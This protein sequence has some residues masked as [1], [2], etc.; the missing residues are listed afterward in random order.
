LDRVSISNLI[1]LKTDYWI[2]QEKKKSQSLI[3]TVIKYIEKTNRL[4]EPQKEAIK[5]YLWLKFVG[6][7]QRLS[8][9]IR[10]GLLYDEELAKQYNNF[11]T[12][13][14]NYTT[15]FLNQFFQD[16][17][18][19]KLHEKLVNDPYGQK[20]NWDNVLNELLYN[21]EY[22]NYL[23]SLP[24]GAGKTFLMACFIYLDL[25]FASL[26]KKDKRFAHNFIVLAPTASKTAI[27]PSLR[28]IKDF[29][30]EWILPKTEA[31]R[32]KQTIQIEILDALSSHRKDKLQGENPN[33]EKVNRLL[34]IKDF[35]LVFITNAEKV[36][37]EKYDE[38]DMVFV[39]A[40]KKGRK[41]LLKELSEIKKSNRLR[42]RLSEIPFLSV[43]LDE[44]HHAYKNKDKEKKS[45][46]AINILN[47]NKNVVS[48]L[49]FSG[50]P[51]VNYSINIG[52]NQIRL[53]Q[54]QDI[55]YN[56]SL[57]EGIGKF[58][59][60]PIVKSD[61]VNE[62]SFIRN[63]LTDFFSNF[64]IAYSNGTKSKM[65]F[66]CPSVKA[67]NEKILPIVK[68]W[69]QKNRKGKENEI[70]RYYSK[71]SKENKLYELPK[72]NL[73]LFHNLD[74]PYSE[75]R[76]VLLVAV[77]TE[78]WDCKSLTAISLPRQQT[79]KNFVLQTTCRCLREVEN[80]KKEKALIYLSEDNYKTLDEELQEN[81]RLRI[82]DL[83][84]RKDEEIPVLVKK[85]KLGKLKYKQVKKKYRVMIKREINYKNKL[86][87]FD[88]DIFKSKYKFERRVMKGTIGKEGIIKEVNLNV[89]E[90]YK[91]EPLNYS[92]IDFVYDISNE[93][94]GRLSES[95]LLKNYGKELKN[96][97]DKI[98]KEIEWIKENPNLELKDVIHYVASLFTR[99]VDYK[100]ETFA[101][102][103]EIELLEW[104]I[105]KPK[106][107]LRTANGTLFK[108]MP[109]IKEQDARLY[110]AHP[111]DLE[112]EIKNIDPQNISFNYIPYRMDSTFEQNAL[113]DMLKMSEL[114][115]LEV[116]YNGFKDKKLNSFYIET[117]RGKYT[118]D[119]LIIKRKDNE[120][121][122]NK[123][124]K[125]EIE[126]ILIIE[127]K[128]KLY[129]DNEFR[130]KERFIE[131][132]F[133]KE[134]PKFRYKCF[135]DK[136]KTNDFS[137]FLSELKKEIKS[138]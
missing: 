28:T 102:D 134:N 52:S 77:G 34:Q 50:T 31:Q 98:E 78:G 3:G 44:V 51:Y 128:G 123:D 91:K 106:M 48:V 54:I 107:E 57:N 124:D 60:V 116:Y 130:V 30:P 38:K 23:F 13:G 133:I 26:Y 1:G 67:L 4:R 16:N 97:F 18:I 99:E 63:A 33:L 40:L 108:F 7:N 73:A 22:P 45:R 11:Y 94:F 6:K 127:T 15:Q 109:K 85:P 8:D 55:V 121:Y 2:N 39:S 24:M 21:Y 118:P 136:E 135:V 32:I 101:E 93:T 126:K 65:A 122:K 95:F 74:K 64:D 75:K 80:A 5:V 12:F 113:L 10:Q 36:I 53:N 17:G 111:E 104:K 115:G 103:T 19:K 131:Q 41:N 46:E 66:Y 49:G 90:N 42:E 20:I 86:E 120:R 129:Y 59:K 87:K 37:L 119:F 89:Y 70:L 72:E 117:P 105:I 61:N 114:S 71:V 68:D 27:L 100:I 82:S 25:Y 9:S 88:I 47:Q 76:V 84:V 81:Y 125:G 137:N 43:F 35:G 29:E 92:F 112:K 69:Y 83:E 56:Y 58:L 79:T 110:K 96:I 14:D 138:L 132:N 62:E